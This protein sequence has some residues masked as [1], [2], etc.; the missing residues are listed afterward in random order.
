MESIAACVWDHA[1]GGGPLSLFWDA[2]QET[3][4]LADGEAELAGTRRG[5]LEQLAAAAGLHDVVPSALSVTVGFASFEQWWDPYTLGV[6]PA[7][8]HVAK[9]DAAQREVLRAACEQRLPA[10]PFDVTA[11]AWC[12]VAR[13]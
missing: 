2:V 6:G 12:V 5:H 10:A 7:G 3:D 9:L 1:G 8:A 4:P 13:A 11:S